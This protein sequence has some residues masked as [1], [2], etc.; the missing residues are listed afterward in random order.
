MSQ[1]Q[2]NRRKH[3]GQPAPRLATESQLQNLL[4][5]FGGKKN[6]PEV[7]EE[8]KRTLQD[9]IDPDQKDRLSGAAEDLKGL[10]VDTI[11][12]SDEAFDNLEK[13]LK[14]SEGKPPPPQLVA[15]MKRPRRFKDIDGN[16]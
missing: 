9:F 3:K 6:T 10:K 15:L 1:N 13:A 8:V 12:L 2:N 16:K 14:E 5:R 7:R 11:I 4:V